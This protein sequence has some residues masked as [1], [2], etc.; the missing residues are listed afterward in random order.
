MPVVPVVL[1]VLSPLASMRLHAA[2]QNMTG[3]V[4]EVHEGGGN[5]LEIS[6]TGNP[7]GVIEKVKKALEN[8]DCRMMD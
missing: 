3:V 8:L 5:S 4:L 2:L 1:S 6:F 7:E